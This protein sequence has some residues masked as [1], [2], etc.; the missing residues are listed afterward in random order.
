MH[1]LDVI[2]GPTV[3][4]I[5]FRVLYYQDKINSIVSITCF[6]SKPINLKKIDIDNLQYFTD[7]LF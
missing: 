2:P 6:M 7:N 5:E 4:E 3:A 1:K